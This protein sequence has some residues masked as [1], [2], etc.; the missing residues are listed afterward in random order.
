VEL[1]LLFWVASRRLRC[2]LPLNTLL[3]L[4]AAAVVVEAAAALVDI[5]HQHLFLFLLQ[6]HIRSPLALGALLEVA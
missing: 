4:A 2:C 1:C 3:L 5:E 6:L